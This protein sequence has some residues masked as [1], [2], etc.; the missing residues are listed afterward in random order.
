MTPKSGIEPARLHCELRQRRSAGGGGVGLNG[1]TRHY[2]VYRRRASAHPVATAVGLENLRII[3]ERQ[4]VKHAAEMSP[5]LLEGLRSY[6]DH[7]LVGE[8][9]GVGLIAAVEFVADKPSK[10]SYDPLGRVGG[11][12]P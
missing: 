8:V 9:R 4:L 12:S 7:P 6:A 1:L 5:I 10:R 3:E 2:T 11:Y